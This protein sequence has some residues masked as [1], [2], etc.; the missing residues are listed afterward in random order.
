M[1]LWPYSALTYEG[2][3][4]PA[5]GT[6]AFQRILRLKKNSVA[7]SGDYKIFF[8]ENNIRFS[9][10]I[11]P[12]TG[13]PI[14]HRMASAAVIHPSCMV[15]D[16]LSTAFMVMGVEKAMILAN[17]N[18]IAALFITRD[19]KGNFVEHSSTAFEPY[20]TTETR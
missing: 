10:L 3:E 17:K 13:R 18:E 7:V 1:Y 2:Y 20:L 12:K 5:I 19:S 14:T 15:A 16:G 9:H 8:E 4:K 6:L 11:D